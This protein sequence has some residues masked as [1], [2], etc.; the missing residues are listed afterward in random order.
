MSRTSAAAVLVVLICGAGRTLQ[1][2]SVSVDCDAGGSITKALAG[3]HAGDTLIVTGTCAESVVVPPEAV[4]ITITGQGK[5]TIRHP[6]GG[7]ATGSAAHVIYVRGRAIT[8]TGFTV[9]GGNDGIHLSGPAHAVIDHNVIVQN[10]GRAIHLDKG[11]VAQ[12]TNNTIENNASHGIN[13]AEQSHARIG[14]LIPPDEKLAPNIIRGNGG[15]GVHIERGATAWIVGNTIVGNAGNG[16]ALDRNSQADVVGNA[17][18]R[19]V[20][21]GIVATHNSGV[22]LM[23]ERTPRREGP[24]QT[25]PNAKNGGVGIRCSVGGYVAGPAGTL[26]GSR[27]SKSI[28]T[29]C[30]DRIDR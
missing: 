26:T 20:G 7:E 29:T 11:S 30:V 2:E 10:R 6:T 25:E 5:A 9:T 21:D 14:F 23:S 19:N 13:V 18:S 16:V 17:I 8:I 15:D 4:G 24:N 27:G 3:L 22:N 1:S 28:D 12:I